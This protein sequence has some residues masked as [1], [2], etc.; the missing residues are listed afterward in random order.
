[1]KPKGKTSVESATLIAFKKMPD[2]FG[3]EKIANRVARLTG[4]KKAYPATTLRKMRLWRERGVINFECTNKLRSLYR[5]RLVLPLSKPPY[6]IN[7]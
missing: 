5:K 6:E 3:G 1:M 4:R 2:K 7:N